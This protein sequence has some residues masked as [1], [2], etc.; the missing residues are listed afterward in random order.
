MCK[1]QKQIL[2]TSPESKSLLRVESSLRSSICPMLER[3][4]LPK[5]TTTTKKK[6]YVEKNKL[7]FVKLTWFYINREI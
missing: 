2:M 4:L 6:P 5:E 7:P 1:K 3:G